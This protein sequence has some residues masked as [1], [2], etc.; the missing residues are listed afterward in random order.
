[1]TESEERK[2]T[3]CDRPI[4]PYGHV[5]Q[6]PGKPDNYKE[7]ATMFLEFADGVIDWG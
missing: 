3:V 2:C 4:G 6:W 7:C 1:M 5:C